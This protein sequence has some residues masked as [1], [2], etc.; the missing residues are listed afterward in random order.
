MRLRSGFAFR[1]R[2]DRIESKPGNAYTRRKP[3]RLRSGFNAARDER[4]FRETNRARAWVM[5]RPQARVSEAIA[6]L[7][8]AGAND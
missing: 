1:E 7:V 6:A 3:A 2:R 8:A 4:G 5:G